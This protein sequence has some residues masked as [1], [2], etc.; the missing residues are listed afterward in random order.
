VWGGR[1]VPKRKEAG[2]NN[3]VEAWAKGEN[4]EEAQEMKTID[5]GGKDD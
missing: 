3:N 1:N 4:W 5:G 2:R